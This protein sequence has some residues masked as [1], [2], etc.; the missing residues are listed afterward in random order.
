MLHSIFFHQ[1]YGN[2][3]L[4]HS[5]QTP[6]YPKQQHIP[7]GNFRPRK[8]PTT[9]KTTTYNPRLHPHPSIKMITK[10]LTSVTTRFNPFRNPSGKTCRVFLASL[11]AD[12]RPRMK[13]SVKTLPQESAEASFLGVVFRKLYFAVVG[14]FGFWGRV[15]GRGG[16]G[17]IRVDGACA[18]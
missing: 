14:G 10:H 1:T 16:R 18:D 13:I 9:R 12:A 11:P 4:Q 17:V 6:P 15:G 2:Q 5:Q 7:C 8:T 3:K